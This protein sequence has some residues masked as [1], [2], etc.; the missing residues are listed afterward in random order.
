MLTEADQRG[1]LKFREQ[2]T[3]IL[4]TKAVD[5]HLTAFRRMMK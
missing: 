4:I 3:R 2:I 5:F 1:D